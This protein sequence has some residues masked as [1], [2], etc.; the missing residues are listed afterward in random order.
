MMRGEQA[1]IRLPGYGIPRVLPFVRPY[2]KTMGA[3][4]VLGCLSSLLDSAFP[5]FNRYA[6]DHFVS[7]GTMKGA[8]LFAAL[9]FL[10][11]V[12]FVLIDYVTMILCCRV[13]IRA[14][15]DMKN[16]A[17]AHLQTLSLSYFNQNSVGYIHARV[18][19]DTAR[20][21]EL[22]SWRF[23]DLV[24]HVSWIICMVI[25]MLLLDARLAL[26]VLLLVPVCALIV[27]V[28]LVL[29]K[30]GTFKRPGDVFFTYV[31]LYAIER[32]AVEGLRA[33]SL[34]CGPV[35]VSQALSLCAAIVCGAALVL[36]R[37]RIDKEN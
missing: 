37:N 11:I 24:W 12:L 1:M 27:A 26:Y 31:L 8:G 6:L 33:D 4:L 32:A 36:R 3:M 30:R 14:G 35:R 29:E 20:I 17:F 16:A 19:S 25:M 22:V 15:K 9:Y 18:M 34:Y 2:Y 7:R 13:E 5:V 23:M 10:A 28:L 21:S